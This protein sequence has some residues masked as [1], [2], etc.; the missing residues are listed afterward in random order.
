[1]LVYCVLSY[2][3]MIFKYQD[4]VYSLVKFIGKIQHFQDVQPSHKKNI[5]T[6]VIRLETGGMIF[7][8]HI[9]YDPA[10]NY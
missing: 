9:L 1:M 6:N 5:L 10:L 8:N 3:L 4:A 2:Q 7:F